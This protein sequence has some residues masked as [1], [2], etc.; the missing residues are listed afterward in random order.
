MADDKL[1]LC[2][3]KQEMGRMVAIC[4]DHSGKWR[5]KFQPPKCV[6]LVFN[7]SPLDYRTSNRMWTMGDD[8]FKEDIIYKHLGISLNNLLTGDRRQT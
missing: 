6:V 4:Y 5:Y 7:E 8:I 3:S 1:V 2:L